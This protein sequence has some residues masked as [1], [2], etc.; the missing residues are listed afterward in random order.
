SGK[1]VVCKNHIYGGRRCS[2]HR[3]GLLQW[4]TYILFAAV[5]FG[6]CSMLSAA[7]DI[8]S[9]TNSKK[10]ADSVDNGALHTVG[11]GSLISNEH[12][13]KWRMFTDSGRD[14]FLQ[15][16]IEQAE[17]FFESALQEAREGFGDRDPHVAAACN[18]LAEIYKI[19]KKVDRAEPL[20]AEA[21][22]IL[23]EQFGEDDIR[24]GAAI[25]NFGQFC[26]LQRKLEKAR[27]SYE[28]K[29]RVLGN[30][31]AEYANTMYRLGTIYYLQGQVKDAVDLIVDSLHILE[32]AGEGESTLCIRRMKYLGQ[33]YM[34]SKRFSEA[35]RLHRKILHVIELSK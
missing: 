10:T 25:D 7:E 2:A 15:G 18:N 11:D 22:K 12:T 34:K 13:A 6:A 35:Q 27:Q 4:V 29:H 9:G 23:E 20:Y 17:R 21:I 26:Q 28:I 3:W 24:V 1:S 8:S 31:H 14:Y 32:E 5:V 19:N 16:N 30:G 33:I